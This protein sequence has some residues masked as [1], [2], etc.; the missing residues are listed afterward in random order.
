MKKVRPIIYSFV[1]PVLLG[2][3]SACGFQLRGYQS[4]QQGTTQLS[5][6]NEVLLVLKD[7][8]KANIVRQSLQKELSALGLTVRNSNEDASYQVPQSSQTA[9]LT[10]NSIAVNGINFRKYELVGVLKE[11]R[12]VMTANVTYQV[13]KDGSLKQH[14][15]PMQIE[16]S[17]QYNQA[18]VSIDDKQ[19]QQ[20]KRW[21][22]ASLAKQV[23]EQYTA[24][25]Q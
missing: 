8:Q 11:V 17:Y 16:H 18:S 1:L 10:A 5:A 19:N 25:S 2:S 20:I 21:L 12:I 7:T 13:W 9:V 14:K 4:N 22:Y 15:Q 23:A 24:L 6:K 3:L